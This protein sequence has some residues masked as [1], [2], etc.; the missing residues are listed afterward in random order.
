MSRSL[1]YLSVATIQSQT[2]FVL[3]LVKV[4]KLLL[5]IRELFFQSA[6]HTAAADSLATAT[7]L[8]SR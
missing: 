2:Q 1:A 4:G 5:H 8:E 7:A 6:A 3:Q